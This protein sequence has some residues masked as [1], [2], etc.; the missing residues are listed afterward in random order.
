MYLNRGSRGEQ[1]GFFG[2][3]N[4]CV[5][6]TVLHEGVHVAIS[7]LIAVFSFS[8]SVESKRSLWNRR[9]GPSSSI[10]SGEVTRPAERPR[11]FPDN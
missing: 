2:T 8:F 7:H 3:E 4:P 11:Q 10:S 6:S 5:G 1:R 9:T